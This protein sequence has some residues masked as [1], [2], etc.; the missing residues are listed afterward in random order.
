MK[1]LY[2]IFRLFKCPHKYIILANSCYAIEKKHKI[3]AFKYY[4]KCSRCGKIKI[5]TKKN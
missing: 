4:M 1:Y 5:T 3:V 2:F